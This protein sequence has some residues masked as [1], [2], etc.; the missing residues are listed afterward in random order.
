MFSIIDFKSR[1]TLVAGLGKSGICAL[2]LLHSKGFDVKGCDRDKNILENPEIKMLIKKGIN[3]EIS[4]NF[5][6][7]VTNSDLIV[8][9]PGI[10]Q[11]ENIYKQAQK[12]GKTITGELETA[13]SFI[14]NP[15][16]AITGTN[17]KSTVTELTADMLLYSGKKV[18]RGGNLGTP[19]SAAVLDQD[20]YD[21]F[22][23]EVSSFQ[24]DTSINFSPNVG[25]ILNITPDHLDRYENFEG[26]KQS[27]LDL[28]KNFTNKNTAITNFNENLIFETKAKKSYFNTLSSH[29]NCASANEKTLEISFNNQT[30]SLS[31]KNFRLKGKHNL[32]NL[33]AAA[34]TALESGA[35]IEGIKKAVETFN[36]LPH[37][38]EYIGSIKNIAFIDDS[39]ATN[40]DS[41]IKAVEGLKEPIS[42]IL[43]GKDKGY[44]YGLM[45]EAVNKK[46]KN[47][48]LIG[49]AAE[50]INKQIG[51]KGKTI[52][53]GTMKEALE[54]G[55]ENLDEKGIV[56][57]SP[58]C[59]SFDMFKNY[60]HRGEVF[61]NSFEELKKSRNA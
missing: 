3:I 27:K 40:P 15:V 6:A 35:N 24:I 22:V 4:D 59:S 20:K 53:A 50:K 52:F 54:K 33:S 58:A 2:K 26:Y 60:S 12:K 61:K 34:L 16:V 49:E 31:L 44:D 11:R 41:V 8:L 57:L 56:L 13:W 43:G 10:D 17:G 14:K 28:F 1:K 38:M 25:L 37:R 21:I 32:D 45:S 19:L 5:E 9:S 29:F 51:F 42:L 30:Q 7:M 36:P 55:F 23:L 47:L 48:I 39:K 18:F 46:V